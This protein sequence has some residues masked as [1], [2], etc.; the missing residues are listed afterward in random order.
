MTTPTPFRAQ[1]AKISRGFMQWCSPLTFQ[2]SSLNKLSADLNLVDP[3]RSKY[4]A[5]KGCSFFSSRYHMH[6]KL[7]Y[8]FIS[9]EGLEWVQAVQY[10]PRTLSD[11]NLLLLTLAI[12]QTQKYKLCWRLPML[13]LEDK[14]NF[15]ALRVEL[16][17][18][19]QTNKKGDTTNAMRWGCRRQQ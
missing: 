7:D 1:S 16:L 2:L 8:F 3:W 5:E 15:L 14:D 4:P 18:Y 10:S 17:A 11:H 9:P 12:P 13:F 6:S 19:L